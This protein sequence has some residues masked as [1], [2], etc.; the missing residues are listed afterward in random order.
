MNTLDKIS[1]AK[2]ARDLERNR[3]MLSRE[4]RNNSE[5]DL[6][7]RIESILKDV[8]PE[9]ELPL[10]NLA[11]SRLASGFDDVLANP[12]FV[13]RCLDELEAS[14]EGEIEASC[15]TVGAFSNEHLN[16][17]TKHGF[18]G[19]LN[20]CSGQQREALA[21]G[22]VMIPLPA[23]D[24]GTL[25]IVVKARRKLLVVATVANKAGIEVQPL[26][27]HISRGIGGE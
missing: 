21:R 24:F 16:L 11:V 7:K 14:E 2:V 10:P 18:L 1:R 19:A 6:R 26:G 22:G 15:S 20:S 8:S 17:I 4:E 13:E 27:S 12:D 3:L 5:F 9:G 23:S 25:K